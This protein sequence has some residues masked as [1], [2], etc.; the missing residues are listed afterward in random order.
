MLGSHVSRRHDSALRIPAL[1]LAAALAVAPAG[2]ALLE[3][4]DWSGNGATW[5]QRDTPRYELAQA[6]S[7][8]AGWR[9]VDAPTGVTIL[10][11]SLALT[12]DPATD[13]DNDFTRIQ[14][15][16][17][18]AVALGAGT[19]VR[20]AGTFDWSEPFALADWIAADYG[21]LMPGGVDDI[22]ITAAA[23]GSAVI[24]GPGELPDVYWEAF[25]YGWGT[26][27]KGWTIS[28]LDV[29]GFEWT[30][31][32]FYDGAGG[33][34]V[35]DFDGLSI[36]DNRIEVP[37]DAAAIA[38]DWESYQN[39]A[40][41]LGFGDHQTIAGNEIVM[42]GTGVSD[43]PNNAGAASVALQ[44]NSSGGNYEDGLVI[45]D[46][47]IR[48]TGAQSADPEY[49][50]G[51][52]ENFS[53]N[54]ANITV[55]GN[56]F[57][58]E[59]A[60]NDP[61]LNRQL[62]FRVT[63]H[64]SATSTVAYV[65]NTVVGAHTG[66]G[67]L[68]YSSPYNPPAT[69][70][71]VLVTGNA[72]LDCDTG[73]L[74][75]SDNG[76]GKGTLLHNRFGGSTTG[77]H[78]ENAAATSLDWWGCNGGPDAPGC[79]AAATSAG[80][81]LGASTWL[82]FGLEGLPRSAE[83]GDDVAVLATLRESVGGA[84][85]LS[86]PPSPIAFA[87]LPASVTTP[88]D[89]D[90]G[91]AE[92][93]YTPAAAGLATLS[94]T[95][96]AETVAA[97]MLVTQGGVVT[98]ES[99]AETGGTPTAQ[100]NDY[101]RINAMVQAVDDGVTVR[102]AGTFDWTEPFA[103]AS[104][105]LGSDGLPGTEDDWAILAPFGYQ[106]VTLDAAALGDAVVQ[107]PGD[108]P[109]VDLE[110]FLVTWGGG[111]QGW[112]FARL[113]L[114]GFDVALGM[115]CCDGADVANQYD[116]V[117][118][119]DNR[120]EL[121][122]DW[123][124]IAEPADAFQNIAIHL[125]FGDHQTISGNEIVMPG[126]GVSDTSDPDPAN[127]RYATCVGLQ[128]NTSGGTAY[129]G[130]AITGNLVRVT[131]APSAD[132]ERILGIWENAHAHQSNVTVSGNELVNEDAG[133]DPAVNRQTAFRVTSHSSPSTVVA[134]EGN[135]VAGANVAVDLPYDVPAD[136]EPVLV[137]SNDLAGNGTGVR[138]AFANQKVELGF[139]RLFGNLLALDAAAG[140]VLAENNWWG[141]N[142]GPGS[143]G[144]DGFVAGGG[145]SVDAD[146]WLTLTLGLGAA[147]VE[148]NASTSVEAA[149]VVNSDLV[150]TSVGG[151]FVP[152]G[153]LADFGATGGV[154]APDPAA[155]LEGVAAATFTAGGTTGPF[156]VAVT[157][158]GQTLSSGG[159]VVVEGYLFADGF[160]TGDFTRWS[161]SA[162]EI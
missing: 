67:W 70:E 119:V 161:E 44:S 86:F 9:R 39:V 133:N 136:V 37:V 62:G 131:G 129:D 51:I 97:Q 115:F 27:Y 64:S 1:L 142:A 48:V 69:V 42:P 11:E 19:T 49:L 83:V 145:A 103:A 148:V 66:I 94:A 28:N 95:L 30:F 160:E 139:N 107:G 7:S 85:A 23:L 76:N 68:K 84:L 140:T 99:V 98:V 128:S 8:G 35:D 3:V 141:C 14:E 106:D 146:P 31:G 32:F 88:H 58:N 126:T 118:V 114:R 104:W 109:D 93:V 113:D 26:T 10:V 138:L 120:I 29:R 151:I 82:L 153:I 13:G 5:A 112:T 91:V 16:I 34:T 143:A 123:N 101:T 157:V 156:E 125:G 25:L 41:H 73:V 52:W 79:A 149:L 154:V 21:L 87:A 22:T 81:T 77:V 111:F 147:V 134:Y 59:D 71:P 105:E 72:L 155:T 46:N 38:P 117:S 60:G 20:L 57:V 144:C 96:D 61:A 43:T 54:T 121:P 89:T 45:A 132:P 127:W 24:Q 40:I 152:D 162:G 110:S 17:A 12:G 108:L 80:G 65:G 36:L 100:D 137:L 18:A 4:H 159:E 150:D 33:G 2:A 116:G 135:R 102:L 74:V 50:Y 78:A 47:L 122:A 130:L 158:D 15:G 55:S 90:E 124:A 53:A 63:S 6:K 56:R 92:A 75:R